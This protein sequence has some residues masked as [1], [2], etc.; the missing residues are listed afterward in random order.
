MFST[1]MSY[2]ELFCVS[3][4][5]LRECAI[6]S[7]FGV[8]LE[9]PFFLQLNLKNNFWVGW[10]WVCPF[11]FKGKSVCLHF[12]QSNILEAEEIARLSMKNAV[13]LVL[14]CLSVFP[15]TCLHPFLVH[16]CEQ[17][18]GCLGIFTVLQCYS[19]Y[20]LPCLFNTS[21]LF[22]TFSKQAIAA[23]RSVPPWS[24]LLIP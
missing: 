2:C 16:D 3:L 8:N 19:S 4:A 13:Y 23:V 17:C 5:R 12:S 20:T 15:G 10:F 14:L 1:F 18:Q 22:F 24:S 21:Y 9:A 7:L 11:F 6:F